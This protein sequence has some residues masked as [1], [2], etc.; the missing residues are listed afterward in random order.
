M[1]ADQ[2]VG[3]QD[4]I[5]RADFSDAAVR[6]AAR[7]A[8]PARRHANFFRH[9]IH[10]LDESSFAAVD[11][12]GKNRCRVI[13]RNG[14]NS[15]EEVIDRNLLARPQEHGGFAAALAPHLP[16]RTTDRE[17]LVSPQLAL[18]YPGAYR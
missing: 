1:S 15:F 16:T 4:Q 7:R 9:I 12:Y 14:D 10:S 5:S 2:P 11:A 13:P 3:K 17:Q 18:F 8:E 6:P